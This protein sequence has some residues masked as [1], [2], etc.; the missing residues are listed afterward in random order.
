MTKKEL[1]KKEM[2][3]MEIIDRKPESIEILMDFG[4]GCFSCT[5][6]GMETLEEGAISHGINEKEIERIIDEINKL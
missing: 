3:I 5:F 2:T 6:S 1:V 4:L